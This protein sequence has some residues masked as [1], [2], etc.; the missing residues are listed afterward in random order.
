[1][2]KPA[3]A[4]PRLPPRWGPI[5]VA[6]VKFGQ[7]GKRLFGTSVGPVGPAG[8]GV[9]VWD[10]S[11][12]KGL[13]IPVPS[14]SIV[15]PDCNR[16]ASVLDSFQSFREPERSNEMEVWD[17][18][19]RQKTLTIKGNGR[20]PKLYSARIAFNQDGTRLARGTAED[21]TVF[22]A[23]TGKATL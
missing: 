3:A 17:A 21:L 7:D 2:F 20:P 18:R 12:G 11:T 15:S 1:T 14:G 9:T 8:W 23:S 22:D 16:L 4:P 5:L 13:P 19:T 10:T 6:W